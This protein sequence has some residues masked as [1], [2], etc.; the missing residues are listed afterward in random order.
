MQWAQDSVD[1]TDSSN[2]NSKSK[3]TLTSI[4]PY[5]G[6]QGAGDL[7]LCGPRPAT[8]GGIEVNDS[9]VD[10]EDSDLTQQMAAAGVSGP[11]IA[12]TDG[13][14]SLRLKAETAFTWADVDGS[15]TLESMDL[16]ADRQRLLVEGSHVRQLASGATFTPSV[17][18][19]VRHDGGDGDTGSSIETGAGVRYANRRPYRIPAMAFRA[20]CF[21]GSAFP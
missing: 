9:A 8:A 7:S 13:S 3:T 15:G 4:N 12:S 21:A 14:M 1:Y 17:E 20:L 16:N 2:V 10:E 11:L 5:V 6:W 19:G 18:L